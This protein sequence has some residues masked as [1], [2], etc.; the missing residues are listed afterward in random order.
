MQ[1][2]TI[3]RQ[4]WHLEKVSRTF[5]L[6]IP[7]LPA[8]LRDWVGN[9]YLLCR[10]ADTIEDDPVLSQDK[11]KEY[12]NDFIKVLFSPLPLDEWTK[13]ITSLLMNSA[14]ESEINLIQDSALVVGRYYSYPAEVQKILRH[15]IT[16]MCKGMSDFE[17][18]SKINSLEDVDRYCYSVAGVVGELLLYLFAEHSESI[19]K[20][21]PKLHEL[22]V[23]FGEAL[24]LTNILKDVW[25][26]KARGAEWLPIPAV[27]DSKLRAE[28]I[29][30]Y[31][32]IAYGH[33]LQAL[34]FIMLIPRREAGIRC[35]CI[36]SSG[37]AVQNLRNIYCKPLF[38]TPQEIKLTR[39]D[40]YRTVIQAKVFCF[41][42]NMLKILY[43]FYA[44]NKMKPVFR[45]PA[46]LCRRVSYW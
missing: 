44:G 19:K 30:K 10:I 28:A 5:A 11:K 40:V 33:C 46:K 3:E 21:L 16:I 43:T 15:A 2:M 20:E 36:L 13:K 18:W 35:F 8:D 6:T 45:D 39:K 1:P 22:A 7:F 31:V 41:S 25:D 26:D 42:N 17:R 24:Q 27:D 37:L 12:L 32:S 4:N 38:L 9:A 14:K 34:D 29:Q 23:S